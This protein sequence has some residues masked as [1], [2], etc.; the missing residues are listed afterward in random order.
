MRIRESALVLGLLACSAS[1]SAADANAGK[2]A[3]RAQ[4]ALCHSAEPSDDG[5]A[6]GPDLHGVFG[7]AAAG[8]PAFT[9]T[10]ALR[11]SKLTWDAA[12]LDRFLASPTSVVPGSSMVIP[13]PKPED[14]ENIIAYFAALKEGSFKEAPRPGFG[15]PPGGPRPA[16]AAPQGEA[17]W[18][19]DKPGR[20]HRVQVADLPK[21]FATESARNFPRVVP[22]PEGAQPQA[23]AGFKVGTF[24]Q[25]L[26]GPRLMRR[27]PN[28]DIFLTETQSGR[29]KVLRP[30]ADG[31]KAAAIE[32]FAQ[33]LN[34]PFGM[35]FHPAAN[36]QWLYVAEINR[37]VRYAYT[38][39]SQKATAVP[40]VVVAELSP[41]AGGHFTRDIAFS[42][43]GKLLYVSVGSLTNVGE[44][45]PKKTPE[46]IKAWEAEHG[47]GAFWGAETNR[48]AVLVFEVGAN[49]PGKIFAT[50]I[51]NCVG[52][53]VQ[54]ANGEVWC[55]T[56]ERDGLGDDLVPD[57]STR[58][59]QGGYYGWPWYY[60][61][62]HEDPRLKGERPDLAGKATVP[63]VPFTA[64]SAA[65]NLTFYTATSGASA[66]PKE[67][68]GDA[69]AVLHGSWNRAFRTGHKIVRVRMKNDVP[70][71]EYEDFVTGF[72][73]D[74]G[75][76]WARPVAA[77][78]M[79]DGSL[80]MSEDGNNVI[81]RISYSR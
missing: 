65:D 15:P 20:V 81:Y 64:H 51:R 60:M 72:I 53:T 49:K 44:N 57:Y 28:G 19:K 73:V 58:V 36:P 30:S 59:K 12:T 61:G 22:R 76:A 80:L 50:G 77:E 38:P 6:Q 24:A 39:G 5:G 37:V 47:L 27:A 1:A 68:V 16:A 14:R 45:V 46:E 56:N 26:Q 3:F 63:D 42:R 71:G 8:N 2:N 48:A 40:E 9:Y 31:S 75:N 43:D 55:T 78:V 7:R 66:F 70:T 67:Y 23:P 34:Q 18:K 54:P 32:V 13:V 21:P 62:N 35:Q 74:D 52:L 69:F 25:G 4:C 41:V 29:V 10:Q 79:A 17:D 33:G 11:N